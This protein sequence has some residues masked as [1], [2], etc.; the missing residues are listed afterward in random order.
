MKFTTVFSYYIKYY[1]LS[2]IDSVE[3]LCLRVLFNM[4]DL[5]ELCCEKK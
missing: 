5:K 4:H 3:Q 2:S 1:L